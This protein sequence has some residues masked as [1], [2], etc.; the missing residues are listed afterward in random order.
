MTRQW[1][2]RLLRTGLLWLGLVVALGVAGLRPNVIVITAVVGVVALTAWLTH[3]LADIAP[4]VDWRPSGERAT[5]TYGDDGRTRALQRQLGDQERF[6]ADARLHAH[7]VGII[8]ERLVS[9]HGI[10]RTADPQRAAVVLGPDLVGF[11]AASVLDAGLTDPARLD[12]IIT[13]IE[14]IGTESTT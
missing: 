4:P 10:D 14:A 8:D 2:L 3:D 1:R 6:G 5:T 9:T 13:R 7:L 11:I 12:H